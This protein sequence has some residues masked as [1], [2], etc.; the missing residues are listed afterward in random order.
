M[1]A[2]TSRS[3]TGTLVTARVL[4]LLE[5]WRPWHRRLWDVGTVLALREAVEAAD[6]VG[7]HVLSHA[8]LAWYAR[9]SLLP[10]LRTDSALGDGQIRRHLHQVCA[11][12]IKP[13]ARSQRTLALLSD[14][15]AD[16]Y[17]RRW[18]AILAGGSMHLERSARCIAAHL[19]DE[20]FHQDFLRRE[21]KSRLDGSTDS[22][23]LI[24]LLI[25]LESRGDREYEGL[26]IIQDK[27]PAPQVASKSPHW[28]SREDVSR[29][30]G[31]AFPHIDHVRASGGLLFRVRA[32]DHVSAVQQV[33][34]SFD[35]VR[36]RVRYRRGQT[37]LDVYP[38][39]FISGLAEPQDFR[40]GDP[41]VTVL[42]LERVGV[43]YDLPDT[44][45]HG[46]RIDDALELA[47]PLTESSPSTAVAGAWAAVE[48]LLFCDT[49]DA[50]REEGRAVAAD[51]AAALVTAGW[52]RAELTALSYDARIREEDP[53]LR[54]DLD[55]VGGNNRERARR[56]VRW[57]AAQPVVHVDDP[58]TTAAIGRMRELVAAPSVTLGRVERYLRGCF[59]R[60]Y[61]QRNIVL[62]GGST[63]SVALP[64]TVRT[65]GP[66]VGAALDRLAHGHAVSG[67]APLDL[68][69]RAELAL[70]VVDDVDG[71]GPHE[72][73]DV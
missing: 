52:P 24:D 64:S 36:N 13:G 59:R 38:K 27:V 49:D 37:A 40:R 33:T 14:L 7:R 22:V 62:H 54:R 71:W 9:E 5:S 70:R 8:S 55:A 28:V 69:G 65:A 32:R 16:G 35:R 19:L 1:G 66:L 58:V 10:R 53:R 6:W 63:R 46:L 44:G 12:P 18:R 72:L 29:L 39:V 48:S 43:L 73:L 30:L 15:V 20:G 67:I 11:R 26:I 51:R 50:D 25:E 68:A 21:V 57:L 31:T 3:D 41:A 56:M 4:E 42:S 45:A 2:V 47:A 61:R 17:L 34:E 60:L 23:D